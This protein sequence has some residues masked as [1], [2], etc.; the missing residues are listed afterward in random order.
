MPISV[1]GAANEGRT[2]ASTT[3]E[4]VV[5]GE[6]TSVDNVDVNTA[7][8]T[9]VV[10]VGVGQGPRLSREVSSDQKERV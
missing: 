9:V 3:T 8:S 1:G 7:S 2:P 10:V 5:G 4:L 6:D